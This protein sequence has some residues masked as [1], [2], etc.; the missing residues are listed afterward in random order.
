MIL[1][2]VTREIEFRW[3]ICGREQGAVG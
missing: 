2:F 1:V 3:G